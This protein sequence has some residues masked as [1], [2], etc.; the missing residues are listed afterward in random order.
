M[1]FIYLTDSSLECTFSEGLLAVP[2]G[3]PAPRIVPDT[4]L[5]AW[6]NKWMSELPRKRQDLASFFQVLGKCSAKTQGQQVTAETG[7]PAASFCSAGI[8]HPVFFHS[9]HLIQNTVLKPRGFYPDQQGFWHGTTKPLP[10]PFPQTYSHPH[11][12]LTLA[13]KCLT[14]NQ[15]YKR[16]YL[17]KD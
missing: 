15:V 13:N 14:A 9:Y 10:H 7:T 17:H 16:L 3:S 12:C 11:T 4:V 6:I 8:S 1:S 2:D 5:V